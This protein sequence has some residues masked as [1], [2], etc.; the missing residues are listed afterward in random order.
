M[1]KSLRN[2]LVLLAIIVLGGVLYFTASFFKKNETFVVN[3][4]NLNSN[5][6]FV[7]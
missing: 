4:L 2:L 3:Q 6:H 1:K 5:K 7:K